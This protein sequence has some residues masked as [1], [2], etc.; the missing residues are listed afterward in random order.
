MGAGQR[1]GC[2]AAVAA[3]ISIGLASVAGAGAATDDRARNE[4]RC[5]VAGAEL[6]VSGGG[7]VQMTRSAQRIVL[8][9]RG[10]PVACAGG[11]PTVRNIDRIEIRDTKRLVVDLTEG[12]LAPGATDEGDGSSEIEIDISEV[13][14][15]AEVRLGENGDRVLLGALGER[16]AGINLNAGLED[17]DTADPDITGRLHDSA[18][19]I[20]IELPPIG[21]VGGL[22]AGDGD[23]VISANGGP[24][25][26][27][28]YPAYA[29]FFGRGG[30]DH[31]TV[32]TPDGLIGGAFGG[33]GDDTLRGGPGTDYLIAGTGL[34]RFEAGR[35]SDVVD[36]GNGWDKGDCGPGRDTIDIDEPDEV[37]R[38][39]DRYGVESGPRTARVLQALR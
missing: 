23:D 31:L 8:T 9:R 5:K 14:F 34:D 17:P 16:R 38:C 19:P 4:V 25:F 6:R 33:A 30:N 21:P 22:F 26:D 3:L 12:P 39:E 18:A 28:P 27:G 13:R 11:S 7:Y 10:E 35:G 1:R 15:G 37:R 29:A 36:T 24:G 20:P 2:E 32:V